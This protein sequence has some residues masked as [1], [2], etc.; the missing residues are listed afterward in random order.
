MAR[1][2]VRRH[3]LSFE[4]PLKHLSNV[5]LVLV[6]VLF[7]TA[8]A[9]G[10]TRIIDGLPLFTD[11]LPDTLDRDTAAKDVDK[12]PLAKGVVRSW[13][14]SDPPPLPNRTAPSAEWVRLAQAVPDAPQTTNAPLRPA[15]VFKAWNSKFVGDP[16]A[17]TFFRQAPG[18]LYVY[19]PP[20]GA[21]YPRFRFMPNATTPLGLVTNE[22]GWRGPPLPA[23]GA[24]PVV[25]IVFVGASTTVNS[26]Y[27]PYSYPELVGH[28]LKLWAAARN[29]D[30]D[31]QVL[32]AGREIVNSTDIEAIVRT[33]VLPFSPDLVVYYE[34]HNQFDMALGLKKQAGG[35]VVRVDQVVQET[36]GARLL[37]DATHRFALARRLQAALGLV[38]NPGRGEEWPKPDY[39]LT[40]PSPR[41]EADPDLSRTDLP[42]NLTTILRDLDRI[43]ADLRPI[44]TDFALSSYVWMV[45]DGMVLDPVRNKF[46]LEWL[47]ITFFPFRYR[48]L[49][50]MVAFQNRVLRKYAAEHHLAFFDVAKVMPM[51]PDLFTDGIHMTY[52]GVRLHAW[53][54]FQDLVPLVEA[55]L[56]SKSWPRQ[57]PRLERI[58]P[59]ALFTPREIKL[60]CR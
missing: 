40:W 24:K 20:D 37:R 26:H 58:P 22:I 44:G 55:K 36:F 17:S 11:W 7:A 60:E 53:I 27:F 42:V 8:L 54:V 57:R 2:V 45:K 39:E 6:S 56:A 4:G 52:A 38:N 34:G 1:A 32:N 3:E 18:K 28:W 15:E 19:D 12:I 35:E 59:E 23:Q 5:V 30:I 16:C 25:R 41:D 13:F 10:A 48:D 43:R 33:E 51:D 9:E 47:N 50:R 29:L 21:P 14:F 49:E 31:F 46:L